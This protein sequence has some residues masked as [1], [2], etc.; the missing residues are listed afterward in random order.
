MFFSSKAVQ[1][2]YL[3]RLQY[4]GF[5]ANFHLDIHALVPKCTKEI[6]GLS[7]G[8]KYTA[9]INITK[10]ERMNKSNATNNVLRKPSWSVHPEPYALWKRQTGTGVG[11]GGGVLLC[12]PQN[13]DVKRPYIGIACCLSWRHPE[14]RYFVHKLEI[15]IYNRRRHTQPRAE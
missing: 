13:K 7:A 5:V 15:S 6:P 10:K 11:E 1:M 3:N 8:R 12:D 9:R 2:S 4:L 14:T